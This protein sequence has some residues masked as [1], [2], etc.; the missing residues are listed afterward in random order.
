MCVKC[1]RD[2]ESSEYGAGERFVDWDRVSDTESR[3]H[4][5]PVDLSRL[6]MDL[7]K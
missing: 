1:M 6:E 4:D 3:L 5:R 2:M 7:S